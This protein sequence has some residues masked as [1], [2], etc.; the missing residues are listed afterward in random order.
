MTK[1]K[2]E[3]IIFNITLFCIGWIIVVWI[4]HWHWRDAFLFMIGVIL[5]SYLKDK[6]EKIWEKRRWKRYKESLPEEER[7]ETLKFL[8]AYGKTTF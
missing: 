8:R 3:K 4:W 5:F 1:D 6:L 2:K 7:E